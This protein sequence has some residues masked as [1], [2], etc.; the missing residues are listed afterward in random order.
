MSLELAVME[1]DIPVIAAIVASLE[2]DVEKFS[3]AR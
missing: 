1:M 3:P 2:I